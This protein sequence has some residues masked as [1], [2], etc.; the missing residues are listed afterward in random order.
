MALKRV[1]LSRLSVVPYGTMAP[2]LVR[3]LPEESRVGDETVWLYVVPAPQDLANFVA[4]REIPKVVGNLLAEDRSID[5]SP[6]RRC[7]PALSLDAIDPENGNL[8][9]YHESGRA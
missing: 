7:A 2:N 1:F 3:R 6:D 5:L 9:H 4:Y 8:S